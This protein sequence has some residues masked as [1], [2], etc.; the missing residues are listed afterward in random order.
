M[1]D[2][3]IFDGCSSDNQSKLARVSID[4]V[5]FTVSIPTGFEVRDFI[6]RHI[7]SC[8]EFEKMNAVE[9]GDFKFYEQNFKFEDFY[10]SYGFKDRKRGDRDHLRIEFN[11]NKKC[12]K[13]LGF[14][15]RC[16]PF[17]IYKVV[18]FKQ[19]RFCY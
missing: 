17:D 6:T 8:M 5:V 3:I 7:R 1:T 16:I 14:I 10:L 15:F 2:S 4:K 19:A 12:I 9:I 18:K 13:G 11:P